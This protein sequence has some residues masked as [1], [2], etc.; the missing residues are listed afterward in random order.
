MAVHLGLWWTLTSVNWLVLDVRSAQDQPFSGIARFT[1]GLAS[2]LVS[3]PHHKPS[4]VI[5]VG[6]DGLDGSDHF[7]TMLL[8]GYDGRIRPCRMHSYPLQGFAPRRP[9]FLW[10]EKVSR[11]L[12]AS[13]LRSGSTSDSIIWIAPD[14]VD[15]P[16]FSPRGVSVV[17][18]VHDLIPL[19]V[20]KGA[21]SP[22]ALQLRLFSPKRVRKGQMLATVS[23]A[24]ASELCLFFSTSP[25]D[26]VV[27]RPQL[28]WGFCERLLSLPVMERASADLPQAFFS[29]VSGSAPHPMPA[30]GN[31]S[32]GDRPLVLLGIGRDEEYK[33]WHFAAEAARALTEA[34]RQAWFVYVGKACGDGLPSFLAAAPSPTHRDWCGVGADVY[35]SERVVHLRVVSDEFLAALYCFAD[36]L[37]HPSRIEGYGYTLAEAYVAGLP[38]IAGGNCGFWDAVGTLHPSPLVSGSDCLMSQGLSII[39]SQGT[40]AFEDWF[41]WLERAVSLGLVVTAEERGRR[42]VQRLHSSAVRSQLCDWKGAAAPFFEIE[43]QLQK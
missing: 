15:G 26:H 42:R 33:R 34:G 35:H 21:F 24:S 38:V 31:S 27:V 2:G 30:P 8:D 11:L 10:A 7:R 36:L 16:I 19:R 41:G 22:L 4:R 14:N 5:L 13:L 29:L 39:P 43:S 40:D 18:V 20:Q 28:E 37:I 9:R 23:T 25:A 1:R 6:Y 17:Q 12:S 3:C 32:A